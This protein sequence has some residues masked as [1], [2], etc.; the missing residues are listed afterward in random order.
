MGYSISFVY[1]PPRRRNRKVKGVFKISDSKGRYDAR[2]RFMWQAHEMGYVAFSA[3]TPGYQKNAYDVTFLDLVTY[4]P[5]NDENIGVNF[6]TNISWHYK[7]DWTRAVERLGLLRDKVTASPNQ[8]RKE[9]DEPRL[10]AFAEAIK[11][12]AEHQDRNRCF[13]KISY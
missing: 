2:K 12:C 9:Y 10:D 8:H 7:P 3:F 4:G 6:D 1:L 11:K 13:V 5:E